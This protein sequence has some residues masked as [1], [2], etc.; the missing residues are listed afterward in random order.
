MDTLTKAGKGL[1]AL[2]IVALISV[3]AMTLAG[4]STSSPEEE[5]KQALSTKLDA[6][7]N[8]EF[9]NSLINN[10]SAS[11]QQ[12]SGEQIKELTDA[13][14]DGFA[15]KIN[16]AEMDGDDKCRINVSITCKQITR[17]FNDN[18]S[19]FMALAFI[20]QYTN[21]TE[22]EQSDMFLKVLIECLGK[23][24]PT[25]TDVE[26]EMQKGSGGWNPANGIEGIKGAIMGDTEGMDSES[27]SDSERNA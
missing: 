9:V 10:E 22:Q 2:I 19:D 11:S 18:T 5:A 7:K 26:V 13:W 6:F 4:C 20:P 8:G 16:S 3:C 25:T 21:G 14:F 24:E 17:A 27:S 12:I 23:T 1:F 15:H